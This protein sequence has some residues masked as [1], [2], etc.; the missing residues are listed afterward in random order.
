MLGVSGKLSCQILLARP[1]PTNHSIYIRTVHTKHFVSS[2]ILVLSAEICSNVVCLDW[3]DEMKT[4]LSLQ[5][6]P[7]IEKKIHTNNSGSFYQ[8]NSNFFLCMQTKIFSLYVYFLI[9]SAFSHP[10]PPT[11]SSNIIIWPL[12]PP[13]SLMT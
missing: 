7:L 10:H 5:L 2:S 9:T 6:D 13:T 8:K 4:N 12:H 1:M 3:S 11:L